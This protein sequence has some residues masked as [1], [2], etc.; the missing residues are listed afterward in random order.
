VRLLEELLLTFEA[1]DAAPAAPA[2]AADVAAAGT[3]TEEDERERSFG[4]LMLPSL[5]GIASMRPRAGG[6]SGMLGRIMGRRGTLVIRGRAPRAPGGG[7]PAPA[8]PAE[9]APGCGVP[10]AEPDPAAGADPPATMRLRGASD[11]VRKKNSLQ[12]PSRFDDTTDWRRLYTV[13]GWR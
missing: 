9:V 2:V 10:L 5:P 13:L 3:A 12:A 4:G 11:I 7:V 6:R 8:G 1:A